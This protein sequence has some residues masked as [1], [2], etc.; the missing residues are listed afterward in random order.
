V[1]TSIE[2]GVDAV[3]QRETGI[4]AVP[5]SVVGPVRTHELPA[6][7]AALGN[8]S[9]ASSTPVKIVSSDPRRKSILIFVEDQAV[10]VGYTRAQAASTAGFSL[11]A[12]AALHLD[13]DGEVWA[14]SKTGTALVSYAVDQWAD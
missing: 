7:T 13:H 14:R 11:P 6:R 5:V 1:N 2:P 12:G 10:W 9:V 8:Y 3:L 4:V